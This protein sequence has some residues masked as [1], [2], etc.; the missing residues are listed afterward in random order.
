M[1]PRTWAD[2]ELLTVFIFRDEAA[3][4]LRR[5]IALKLYTAIAVALFGSLAAAGWF[6]LGEQSPPP[7]L[8]TFDG[9]EGDGLFDDYDDDLANATWDGRAF[10]ERKGASGMPGDSDASA[11]MAGEDTPQTDPLDPA[12][13]EEA[14][15]PSSNPS[16]AKSTA[17][18]TSNASA[19]TGASPNAKSKGGSAGTSADAT[20]TPAQAELARLEAERK[21]AD[22]LDPEEDTSQSLISNNWSEK[23]FN[24]RFSNRSRTT[25]P[26][27]LTPIQGKIMSVAHKTGLTNATVIVHS[28]FPMQGDERG[29]LVP[30]ATEQ[31]TD[32]NGFFSCNVPMPPTPPR[33]W[34]V[35]AVSVKGESGVTAVK[36]QAAMTFAS[37]QDAFLISAS[38]LSDVK[39]GITN[40]LGV[41]W[42]GSK[43]YTIDCD[44]RG[45]NQTGLDVVWTG[46]F[47]AGQWTADV[48]ADLL[49]SFPRVAVG[50]DNFAQVDIRWEGGTR[51]YF[52]ALGENGVAAAGQV[53]FNPEWKNKV[54]EGEEP[55]PRF[56]PLLFDPGDGSM[57]SGQVLAPDRLG[58]D[59]ATLEL[60]G[61]LTTI[62]VT[63]DVGGWYTVFSA[64]SDLRYV[65]VRHEYYATL[66]FEAAAFRALPSGEIIFSERRPDFTLELKD[67]L[68]QTPITSV[69]L[70]MR[71][72]DR[73]GSRAR[74]RILKE[75]LSA[76]DGKFHITLEWRIKLIEIASLGY[77][78][79]KITPPSPETPGEVVV[80]ELRPTRAISVAPSA[81]SASETRGSDGRTRWMTD[82]KGGTDAWTYWSHLWIEW[83]VDFN[84]G[85]PNLPA[86]PFKLALGTKNVGIVDNA[87]E[88]VVDVHVDGKKIGSM[89][90]LADSLN[91]RF[92]EIDL[93]VM[94]GSHTIRLVWKNDKWIPNEL[95]ANI[96][97][98][99][100][101]FLEQAVE[102]EK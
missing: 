43:R 87:Y 37:D 24:R 94:E 71:Y 21:A 91:E 96:R 93:G 59:H 89:K 36:G 41:I 78:G 95:D 57:I 72:I 3:L 62:N 67:Q 19:G 84:D 8:G 50:T 69:N 6:V 76:E 88:F 32:A 30:T 39:P 7:T 34:D 80:I 38:K 97:I 70:E 90:I 56:S 9:D 15:Q 68:A 44:C 100:L 98:T 18:Q 27:I 81:F 55:K 2:C 82:D 101:R 49:K 20:L 53:A 42:S 47:N 1:S 46:D 86:A 77:A 17:N 54:P 65:R 28:F 64:P 31:Q 52:A 22:K 14:T 85:D 83:N 12:L 40:Q 29:R 63:A 99:S 74:E 73:S 23:R 26:M 5:E 61:A 25:P 33:N 51:P 11:G 58:V 4:L 102:D 75:E 92:G 13:I 16:N 48:Q 35:L 60:I 79:T 45:L 66:R 10:E